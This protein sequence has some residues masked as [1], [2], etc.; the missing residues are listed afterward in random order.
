MDPRE[1]FS[2][3]IG[4]PWQPDVWKVGP[5]TLVAQARQALFADSED[6]VD[7]VLN[8]A[9]NGAMSGRQTSPKNDAELILDATAPSQ[10]RAGLWSD[11]M[12]ELR[13]D[14]PMPDGKINPPA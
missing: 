6:L 8:S 13:A 1:Q 11:M 12:G 14:E 3:N 7:G 9:A 4:P 2:E 5:D 10:S